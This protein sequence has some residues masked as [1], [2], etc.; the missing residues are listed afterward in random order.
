MQ[1][2]KSNSIETFDVFNNE[3]VAIE[4]MKHLIK[5]S[6]DMGLGS[7]LCLQESRQQINSK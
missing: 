6:N 1:Q 5:D 2:M 3:P 7:F 4:G